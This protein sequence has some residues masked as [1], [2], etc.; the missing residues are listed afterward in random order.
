MEDINDKHFK[1]KYR[2]LVLEQMIEEK[3]PLNSRDVEQSKKDRIRAYNEYLRSFHHKNHE[4]KQQ[5]RVDAETI[6]NQKFVKRV[7]NMNG[8]MNITN[9]QQDALNKGPRS[10][11]PERKS[12]EDID[13]YK[14]GIQNLA[15]VKN[16]V[17]EQ[18]DREDSELPPAI[19]LVE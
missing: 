2:Y 13:H 4:E 17:R 12:A 8:S 15:F 9:R 14:Q 1:G 5:Q 18:Q 7:R 19:C 3:Y 10:D 6:S 11:R 16:M